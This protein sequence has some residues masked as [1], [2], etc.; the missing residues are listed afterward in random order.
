VESGLI[1]VE[2]QVY[3]AKVDEALHVRAAQHP[4]ILE[5]EAHCPNCHANAPIADFSG[6][7]RQAVC[8]CCHKSFAPQLGHLVQALYAR[9]GLSEAEGK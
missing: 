3:N 2:Q 7:I 8:P 6:S 5:L 1:A 4:S 9:A